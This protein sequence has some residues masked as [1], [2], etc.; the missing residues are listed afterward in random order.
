MFN[1]S[2]NNTMSKGASPETSSVNLI[3]A[4]T[5]IEGDVNSNS[6]IRIDGTLKGTLVTRGKL[7]VGP[8]GNIEG[9]V[10]C[11]NAD[12]SGQ[13]RGKLNVTELLALKATAKLAGEIAVGKLAIEPGADFSG[14]CSMGGVV[15]D[16][17]KHGAKPAE[18]RQLEEKTA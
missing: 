16:I 11:Q 6:D 4:G 7:V 12:I 17:N 15:K 5:S 9:E 2:K 3:G 13:V 8:S 10:T 18:A 1:S 14:N